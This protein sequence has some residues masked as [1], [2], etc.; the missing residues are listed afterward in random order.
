M[1]FPTFAH[2]NSKN[3][4]EEADKQKRVNNGRN[5]VCIKYRCLKDLA[6]ARAYCPS[7]ADNIRSKG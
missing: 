7:V 4:T 3:E 2:V 6:T 1:L 5:K